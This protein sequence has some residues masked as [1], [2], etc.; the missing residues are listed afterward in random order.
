L[1]AEDEVLDW[2]TKNRF[3]QPELNLFMYGLTA[4]GTTF[5]L[6]TLFLLFCF[7]GH[8]GPPATTPTA[9]AGMHQSPAGA[10]TQPQHPKQA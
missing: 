8:H 10:V 6:Y 2:L 9:N 1:L 5:I 7:K 3:K 4:L